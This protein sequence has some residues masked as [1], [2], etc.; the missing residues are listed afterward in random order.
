MTMQNSVH[1]SSIDRFFAHA[2][3]FLCLVVVA[4]NS[5]ADPPSERQ[6][7]L[8]GAFAQDVTPTQLP[9][10]VN[11]GM[12]E[13]RTSAVTDPLF[14]RC[15]VLDNGTVRIAFSIVDSC[16][17]PNWLMDRAKSLVAERCGIPAECILIS[18]THSHSTPS[19]LSVLGSGQNDDYADYLCERIVEGIVAAADRV[20][21][22]RIG[23]GVGQDPTNVFCR[24]FLM[25]PGTAMTNPFG[26]S[27]DD[28]AQMN[29]GFQNPDA[30]ERTGPADPAVSVL[31][32]QTRDGRPL[33][34]LAN[35]STHYAG[36][37]GLSAD[38]FGVFARRIGELVGAQGTPEFVGIM[39]NGT[40]GDANCL[41]FVNP[42][43][44]FDYL[45]VGDDVARA[46]FEAYQRIEYADWVPLVA[47]QQIVTLGVRKPTSEEVTR[48]SALLATIGDRLPASIPE[49]YARETLL[50]ADWPD[51]VHVTLQTLR[52]GA[53][54]IAAIPCEVYGATGLALK[55]E[56]P[57]KPMFTVSLANGYHGYLPP[58]EQFPLGGY[59]TW[60]ARS[61]Y[62]EVEAEPKIRAAVL[63]LLARVAR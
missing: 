60:R 40:S 18:A 26:G 22:A 7:L 5:W 45:S 21:P 43:R 50:L 41:D 37:P 8:A 9:V 34:I 25:K 44:K 57:I 28:Q 33:A 14:A 56:S 10:I 19:V 58:A 30:V 23:W 38:Y 16:V 62:L 3:V 2:S 20:E 51:S 39:T 53:M 48:A 52:I 32:V 55:Q 1:R 31:S 6:Q 54:G 61:S 46:A 63:D 36:A 47:E 4:G 24:R 15:L 42:P 11:G 13:Q 49:V 17:L 35:Y 27:H 12:S 59:T 29:P